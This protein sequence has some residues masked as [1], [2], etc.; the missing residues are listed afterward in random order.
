MI[1]KFSEILIMG[2]AEMP[3]VSKSLPFNLFAKPDLAGR[4]NY[5][6]STIESNLARGEVVQ[7][8]A[9]DSMFSE[10]PMCG[11]IELLLND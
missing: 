1:L 6:F 2:I 4:A 5:L 9:T 11:E 8:V 10:N 7:F 3:N